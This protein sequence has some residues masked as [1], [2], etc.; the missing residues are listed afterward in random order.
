MT[1]IATLIAAYRGADEDYRLADERGD[2]EAYVA[3]GDI[4]AITQALQ[5]LLFDEATRRRVLGAAPAVLGRYSWSRAATD[6]LTALEEAA[7]ETTAK[8]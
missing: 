3:N 5:R 7:V 1:T 8:R 2:Y 6:T 4:A